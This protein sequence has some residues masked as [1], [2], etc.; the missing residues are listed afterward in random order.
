MARDLK[1][2]PPI[3]PFIKELILG[4]APD[5]QSAKDERS[6]TEAQILGSLL[7]LDAD[8]FNAASALQFLFGDEEVGMFELKYLGSGRHTGRP[9]ATC[10]RRK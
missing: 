5:G 3:S 8:Y 9:V 4:Q 2:E 1:D 10:R 7:T 6:R